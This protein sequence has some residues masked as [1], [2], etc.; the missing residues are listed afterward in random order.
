MRGI[1]PGRSAWASYGSKRNYSTWPI[2]GSQI[3]V[4]RLAACP[5]LSS[6]CRMTTPFILSLCSPLQIGFG[7]ATSDSDSNTCVCWRQKAAELQ[8]RSTLHMPHKI[9]ELLLGQRCL[10]LL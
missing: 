4:Q 5:V 7:F 10:T 2:Q 1:R 6:T 8:N 9:L 3:L